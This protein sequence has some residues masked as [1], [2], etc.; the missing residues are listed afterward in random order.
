MNKNKTESDTARIRL[1]LK[2]RLGYRFLNLAG[3]QMRCLAEM[4]GPRYGL[5]IAKWKVLSIIGYFNQLSATELG[6]Y[7][8]LELDK[9]TRTVDHLVRQGFVDR[10][11]DP[12]DRRRVI[13]SLTAKGKRVNDSIEV[14]RKAIEV[15]LLC[16]LDS[17]QLAS[18]YAILDKLDARAG[19]IFGQPEAWRGICDRHSGKTQPARKRRPG[20][21]SE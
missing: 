21:T 1:D 19:E 7:T 18:F 8:S 3:Q 4:Y 12:A 17:S 16:V 6:R 15:D 5:T 20:K 9:V 14:V 2:D 10:R 13:L 11:Q